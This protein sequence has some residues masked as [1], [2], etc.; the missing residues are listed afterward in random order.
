[1]RLLMVT[2][3][4]AAAMVPAPSAAA[5]DVI[6]DVH[7]DSLSEG[8][9]RVVVTFAAKAPT[10]WQMSGEGSNV[11]I[12]RFP[13]A[14]ASTPD[15]LRALAGANAIASVQATNAN[16]VTLRISLT[17]AVRA[18]AAVSG[19]VVIV[20]VAQPSSLAGSARPP[21]AQATP[22]A[23]AEPRAYEVVQLHFADVGEVA[24]LLVSGQQVL[25]VAPF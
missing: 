3:L 4:L 12:L 8:Y 11:L 2:A 14:S 16:G 19:N 22:A 13:N 20:D 6:N 5:V 24:G 10:D 17:S 25:P 23:A 18:V 9:S 7:V 1:M 21:G 15:T